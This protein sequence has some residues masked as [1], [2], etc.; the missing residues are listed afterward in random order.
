MAFAVAGEE[1]GKKPDPQSR[2]AG[3][4]QIS[5]SSAKWWIAKDM[6]KHSQSRVKFKGSR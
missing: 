1:A 6:Q 2:Q 3:L 4:P 5:R